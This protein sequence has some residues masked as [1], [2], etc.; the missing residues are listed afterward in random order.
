MS[1]SD[2]NI[3]SITDLFGKAVN[4]NE[5]SQD[6]ADI[7][8]DSLND[9]N[10]LG[11]TGVD[12]GELDAD[13]VTLVSLILDTSYS[14]KHNEAIVRESYDELIIKAMRDSKQADSMLVSARTFSDKETV[15]YG[16]KKVADIGKIGSQYT[17]DGNATI[18][19]EATVNAITAIRAY[20]KNLNDQGVQAKC[21]VAVFSDGAN[22]WGKYMQPDQVKKLADDC[23]KAEMFY[24]VY[25]GFK[26]DVRDNL[27]AIG[28]SMGFPNILTASSNPSEV[29]NA[30]GLVSQSAIRKSQTGIGP[31]N[32]FF[33]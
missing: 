26:Q 30:F 27:E 17:A 28:K 32:S 2:P 24:L 13:I 18:L 9:T 23:I 4:D 8:I 1:I 16:F 10:I 20:A 29:R 21:I 6:T 14:M 31:S 33:Q 15:L 22:N 3:Q 19:Y 7:M 12:A 25:V 5:I 11:C